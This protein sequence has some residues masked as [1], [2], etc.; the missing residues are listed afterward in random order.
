MQTEL[1]NINAFLA[2]RLAKSPAYDIKFANDPYRSQKEK[3]YEIETSRKTSKG[4]ALRFKSS[5][6]RLLLSQLLRKEQK[7]LQDPVF[8]LTKNGSERC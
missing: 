7:I 6:S 3:A 1:E 8:T 5:C 2:G 4:S